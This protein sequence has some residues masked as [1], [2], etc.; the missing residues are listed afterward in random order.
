M[1]KIYKNGTAVEIVE[2]NQQK[3]HKHK[4]FATIDYIETS[5]SKYLSNIGDTPCGYQ[6]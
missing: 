3:I 6:Q 1:K 2:L 5:N 4:N